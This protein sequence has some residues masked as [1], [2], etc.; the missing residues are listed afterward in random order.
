VPVENAVTR[1]AVTADGVHIAYQVRG[2]GSVDLVWIWGFASCF[3]VEL[4]HHG[5]A[6]L[7]D[8]LAARWRV[9]LFDK[10]GTGLS[11]RKQT[12]DLEMRAD[13]LRAVLDAVGSKSA[14]LVG[15]S[16]GAAL[17]AFFAASH[18][19]RVLALV[20]VNGWA[21]IAWAPDYPDGLTRERFE[22][23]TSEIAERWGTVEYARA[24]A[25]DEMPS[26]ARDDEYLRWFAREMRYSA[27]PAAAL[28]FQ[29]IWYETDVRTILP[30]VQVPTLVLRRKD[31]KRHGDEGNEDASAT[32]DYLAAQIPAATVVDLP[33]G[34]LSPIVGDPTP[35]VAAIDHF[36][37][38]V[39]D[40]QADLERVLATVLFT[41]I[42]G[43]TERAAEIGD[44]A[45][46]RLVE[47]HNQ[48]VRS[49]LGRFRGNEVDT[50]G[51]GFFATFDGPGRAIRCAHAIIEAMR[52]LGL[53]LRAG[54]HTGE[55]ERAGHTVRGLAVHIGARVGAAA[56]PSEVLVSSTVRDLV[57]GSEL[58][59]TEAGR[60]QLKGVPDEWHLYRAE[61]PRPKGASPARLPTS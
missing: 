55:V 58:E 4:E 11:D 34:D 48:I 26:L 22:T 13:D 27:S 17:A 10:R 18:P 33:G 15:N 42:V 60:H 41:D 24:W 8:D 49:L 19:D 6:R 2:M 36:L 59:F 7:I 45:W 5:W 46:R 40:E 30:A 51:D 25:E 44:R 57:V 37:G 28:E 31:A 53:E 12:P 35:L 23:D 16:E 43:S 1:Y 39:H 47:R 32:L 20:T 21:R 56:G 54:A 61:P 14:V 3:E 38:R 52:P 9:I 50:A 29:H